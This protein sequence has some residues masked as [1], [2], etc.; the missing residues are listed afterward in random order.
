MAKK[1]E[2]PKKTK[3]TF[4]IIA[5]YIQALFS[6]V[7]LAILIRSFV[8]EP[9]KIPSQSMV[10][11]LLVGDHIFVARYKY[12]LRVPFTKFW[13]KEFEGPKRGDVVVFSFPDDE[14]VDFIKRVVGLPGD[15]ITIAGG[16]LNVNGAQMDETA[17]FV[18]GQNKDNRCVMDLTAGSQ[19]I[20]PDEFKAFPH[21]IGQ[22]LFT[23]F[24]ETFD[25]GQK[26]MIQHARH[27]LPGE[28]FEFVV[29]ERSYFVM[30][31][32]RDQSHDSRFWGAV[33]RENL[34]GKAVYI[35]LSLYQQDKDEKN[36][37]LDDKLPRC[38]YNITDPGILPNVRWDRFG[39][40]I[41]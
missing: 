5:E 23:H 37:Q 28:D 39:R 24:V 30:G 6:A 9:F 11:S 1:N 20:L 2:E 41:I 31:D 29:P 21:Y 10:P 16:R 33:P 35:W 17:F 19:K 13:L 8:F 14:D 27:F 34:K 22:D 18:E 15:R 25:N 26:H 38:P 7:L 4:Q 32:N 36:M 3:N 12:G 40:R